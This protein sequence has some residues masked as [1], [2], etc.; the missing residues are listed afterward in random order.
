MINWI[1][2]GLNEQEIKHR[3]GWSRG[4]AQ[5]LRV[6][7]NYTDQEINDKIYEIYGLKTDNKRHIT[8]KACPRCNNVL[9]PDDKFCSQCSLVLDHEALKQVQGHEKITPQLIEALVK[10]DFGRGVLG[11]LQ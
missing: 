6:Y 1:L 2:Y 5:M 8:L 11:E 7:A 10:S 9:R 3:A 4:S